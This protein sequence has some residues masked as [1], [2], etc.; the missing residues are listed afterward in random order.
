M[1]PLLII[2]NRIIIIETCIYDFFILMNVLTK[3]MNNG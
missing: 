3:K 1:E 2:I